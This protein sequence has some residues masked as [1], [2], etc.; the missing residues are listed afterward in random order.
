[1]RETSPASVSVGTD[2]AETLLA[3]ARVPVY[4]GVLPAWRYFLRLQDHL[5]AGFDER[6]F[7]EL[8]IE[9][10]LPG[11]RF[12]LVNDP[13][14]IRHIMVEHPRLFPKARFVQPILRPVVGNGLV[15]SEGDTWASHRRL[16]NPAFDLKLMESYS[17]A[18]CEKTLSVV[19]EWEALG[20]DP[21]VV[22]IERTM[23]R[24]AL[25]IIGEAMF[26]TDSQEIAALLAETTAAYEPEMKF[27]PLGFVPG[28]RR[29]WG[30]W[31]SEQGRRAMA[32]LDERVYALIRERKALRR[33]PVDLL[34]RLIAGADE[35]SGAILSAEEVRD[36]VVTVFIAGHETSEL[37]ISWAMYLLARS[38]EHRSAVQQELDGV[39]AAGRRPALAD[40]PRLSMLRAVVDE[41]LR[42]YPPIHTLS[43]REALAEQII[44]GVTVRRGTIV[45]IV[46]Y[47]L[48]RHH[49]FWQNPDQFDPERFASRS[50][51]PKYVYLPF[52]TGP[53]VCIGAQFAI[54]EVML[55]LAMLLQRFTPHFDAATP[56]QP[57]GLITLRP[58][59][60]LRMTVE[61]R[62][63]G[64]V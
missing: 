55:V 18:I 4:P 22:D 9:R 54:T 25:T 14:W 44:A 10:S 40:L 31:R 15:T 37:A 23:K 19:Q 8:V 42:L 16:M 36:Q 29:L 12:L 27:N 26:S 45:S 38:P 58:A 63:A 62:R 20:T 50:G 49:R 2:G 35:D 1:M 7:R 48:H 60:G 28:L 41:T 6:C 5:L 56:V 53:R 11:I 57:V 3:P 33:E 43:F 51:R 61:R 52:G 39:L 32:A 64:A 30:S 24:L 34:D 21:A 59:D 46:P 47:V 13:A 17:R